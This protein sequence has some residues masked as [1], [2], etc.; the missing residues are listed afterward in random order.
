MYIV[1]VVMHVWVRYTNAVTMSCNKSSVI[2]MHPCVL[3]LLDATNS[4]TRQD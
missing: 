1:T 4:V 3:M 2:A